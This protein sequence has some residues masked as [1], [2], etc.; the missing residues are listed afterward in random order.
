MGDKRNDSETV[1]RIRLRQWL[2]LGATHTELKRAIDAGEY[3]SIP[4]LVFSYISIALPDFNGRDAPWEFV[5]DLFNRIS[6]IVKL[7]ENIPLLK[8]FSSDDDDDSPWE[9]PGRNWYFWAH[10]IA[11]EYGWSLEYIAELDVNDAIKLLQEILVSTQ[12]E[13]EWSWGVSDKSSGYDSSTKTS[14]F[15]PLRRP[16][17]MQKISPVPEVIKIH[18]DF[19]PVGIIEHAKLN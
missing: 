2:N 11:K 7:D 14:R 12:L 16:N 3:H 6:G 8:S 10:T 5:C 18:R 19:L 9:Y 17:W 1:I 15:I 13:K 4:E